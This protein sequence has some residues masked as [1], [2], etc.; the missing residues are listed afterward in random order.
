VAGQVGGGAGLAGPGAGLR[1]GLAV[2]DGR[3]TG[4]GLLTG[5][6][7]EHHQR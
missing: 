5:A 7:A 1:R 6:G 3:R 4:R 2:D